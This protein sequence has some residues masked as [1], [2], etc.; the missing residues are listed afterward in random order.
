MIIDPNVV[1]I[2]LVI[3][4]IGILILAFTYLV[5]FFYPLIIAALLVVVAY[6]IYR[7]LV[8]GTFSF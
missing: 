1:R 7:F 5:E 8:T 4:V 6:F 2:V 3:L